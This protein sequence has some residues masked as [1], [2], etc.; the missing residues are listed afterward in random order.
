[1]NHKEITDALRPFS[2]QDAKNAKCGTSFSLC[3]L[4]AFAG[5]IPVLGCATVTLAMWR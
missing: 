3:G 1:M 2:R 5:D 4:C